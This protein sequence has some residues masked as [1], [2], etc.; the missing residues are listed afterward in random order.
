[1]EE[2]GQ[3]GEQGGE[4]HPSDVNERGLQTGQR[5]LAPVGDQAGKESEDHLPEKPATGPL[6]AYEPDAQDCARPRS[7]EWEK[8]AEKKEAGNSPCQDLPPAVGLDLARHFVAP[9]RKVSSAQI[10]SIPM[11]SGSA[12]HRRCASASRMGS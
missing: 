5:K 11:R 8:E 7:Q 10:R 3:Y 9:W 6:C 12:K 4:Q 2:K 1:M